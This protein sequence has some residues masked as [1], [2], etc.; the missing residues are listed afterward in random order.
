MQ[1]I[2][3]SCRVPVVHTHDPLCYL[4]RYESTGLIII[5]RRDLFAAAMSTCIAW[6]T[7][8]TT[9]YT[10]RD[11]D[12]IEIGLQDFIDHLA[13]QVNYRSCHDFSRPYGAIYDFDFEDFVQDHGMVLKR[14]GLVQDPALAH[15]PQLNNPAPYN[16]QQKV[17]NHAKIRAVFDSLDLDQLENPFANS[18]GT[19]RANYTIDMEEIYGLFRKSFR[20]L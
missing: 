4:D 17:T 15:I 14:L 1:A 6:I 18:Y 12:L 19:D 3:H 16:Y 8:Q 20:P 11:I 7:G 2:L 10:Q 9:T 13:T 5:R